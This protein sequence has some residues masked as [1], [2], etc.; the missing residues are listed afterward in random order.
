M[1]SVQSLKLP[2]VELTKRM[3][4]LAD[5]STGAAEPKLTQAT[6]QVRRVVQMNMVCAT[7]FFEQWIGCR[8][9]E[10]RRSLR[11]KQ[12]LDLYSGVDGSVHCKQAGAK[13]DKQCI[14]KMR[15][16]ENI[17]NNHNSG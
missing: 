8:E 3:V 5:G 14:G 15:V 9:D 4:L 1:N 7:A 11:Y 12:R 13:W 6:S 17:Y 2:L 16:K 10:E